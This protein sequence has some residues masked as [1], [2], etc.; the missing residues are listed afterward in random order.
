MPSWHS[1]INCVI[2]W[3]VSVLKQDLIGRRQPDSD[4]RIGAAVGMCLDE[5]DSISSAARLPDCA[6][7][8][9][10]AAFASKNRFSD[11]WNFDVWRRRAVARSGFSSASASRLCALPS[12]MTTWTS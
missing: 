6:Q 4:E 11:Q 10:T 3:H 1:R 8:S 12:A 7:T 9:T 2:K 5:R